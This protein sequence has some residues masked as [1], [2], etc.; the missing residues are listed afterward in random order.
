MEN[1]HKEEESAAIPLI[2]LH[3]FFSDY[4]DQTARERVITE[5]GKACEEWGFFQVVNHGIPTELIEEAL[6][7]CRVFFEYPQE[8]KMKVRGEV[9]VPQQ[10]PTGYNVYPP[11]SWDLYENL[12]YRAGRSSPG[13]TASDFSDGNA[14][15][16]AFPEDLP[17]LRFVIERLLEFLGKTTD[18]IESLISQALG[19]SGEYLREL[20]RDKV[21]PLKVLCYPKARTEQ[22]I[23]AW[24]HQDSSCITLV[25]QDDTGGYQ[26]LKDAKW[27]NIKPTRGAL[28]VNVGDILQ[29]WSNN[30]LKS[31]VHRVLNNRERRRC[32]FAFATVPSPEK[33]VSPLPEFTSQ[34]KRPAAYRS[35]VYK[36][37][38]VKRVRNKTHPPA[39]AEDFA[40]ISI[41][42]I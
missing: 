9:S 22:E 2:D 15:C 29:V 40:D 11:G 33:L 7:T 35:F 16:N 12:Y 8:E 34:V 13:Q 37:Y 25:G 30:R 21:E 17:Q 1:H 5:V 3:P 18:L 39:T 23:G 6:D 19:L 27:V 4:A 10:M 20:N 26:V 31:A 24:Q 41:Y 42:A 28:V 36:D 32:S 14:Q 38:M